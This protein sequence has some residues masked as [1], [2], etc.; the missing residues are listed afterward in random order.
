MELEPFGTIPRGPSAPVGLCLCPL[1]F[2]L[3]LFLCRDIVLPVLV[4]EHQLFLDKVCVHL[5]TVLCARERESSDDRG[6]DS[7]S[8]SKLDA[9]ATVCSA[10]A[11]GALF[12]YVVCPLHKVC[13]HQTDGNL[14]KKGVAHLGVVLF[15]TGQLLILESDDYMKRLCTVYELATFLSQ[16]PKNRIVMLPVNLPQ[17][18]FVGSTVTSILHLVNIFSPEHCRQQDL[19]S[20]SEARCVHWTSSPASWL[21]RSGLLNTALGG[22]T[23]E[24]KASP[25]LQLQRRQCPVLQRR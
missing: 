15:F 13:I 8:S 19:P 9:D 23:K 5:K 6:I 18:A 24:E 3:V 1:V 16:H 14:M 21:H 12:L 22:G 25:T 10:F 4:R 2:W 11:F 20:R 7:P 17:Y